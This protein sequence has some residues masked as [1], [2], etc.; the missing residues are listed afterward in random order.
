MEVEDHFGITWQFDELQSVNTVGDFV[1]AIRS[2][3]TAA[4]AFPCPTLVQFHRLRRLV[5]VITGRPQLR[6]RP[7]ELLLVS[8]SK[9]ERRELWRKLSD[10]FGATPPALRRPRLMRRFLA[11]LFF[12]SSFGTLAYVARTEPLLLPLGVL[13]N[14]LF[15]MAALYLTSFARSIPPVGWMTYGEVTRKLTGTVA[16]YKNLNSKTDQ[17]IFDEMKGIIHETTQIDPDSIYLDSHFI[18]DLK[19]S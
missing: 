19:I 2:R 7:K 3:I 15:I 6:A 9:E 11:L 13:L 12:S 4:S 16:T 14:S 5:R 10:V 1:R 8:L 18:E 17:E